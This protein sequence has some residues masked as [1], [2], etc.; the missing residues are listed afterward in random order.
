M[1]FVPAL[2]TVEVALQ[3]TVESQFVYNVLHYRKETAWDEGSMID[4]GTLLESWWTTYGKTTANNT[5]SLNLI[6]MRDLTTVNSLYIEYPGSL[7][8]AGAMA[9]NK[10][11]N[12]VT[13]VLS[14]RTGQAGRSR[15]GR[16]FLVGVEASQIANGLLTSSA[17]TAWVSAYGHLIDDLEAEGYHLT[18]CSKKVGTTP[19]ENA[20]LTDV[21]FVTVSQYIAVQKRRLVGRGD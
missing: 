2:N 7:P 3:F 13:A 17:R 9:G 19:R 6:K 11:P 4:L 5:V 10:L 15:R 1:A 21:T 14:L 18:I 12:S 16:I 8:T 20:V